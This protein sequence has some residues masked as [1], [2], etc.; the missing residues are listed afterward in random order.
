MY[1]SSSC[2]RTNSGICM[3]VFSYGMFLK[4]QCHEIFD[5]RFSTW[6]SFPKA[7]DY[8][9]RAVFNFFKNSRRY[10]QLRVTPVANGK[11]LQLEKAFLISF[12]HLW[13]SRVGIQIKFFL[14]VHFKLSAVW[15]YSHC[16]PPLSTTPSELV[17]KFAAG[18]V[19]ISG[20]P[21]LVIISA[22]FR[23]N[24]KWPLCYFQGLG[25]RWFMKKNLK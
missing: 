20:A 15:Y 23:K 6:I 1:F 19:D 17:A 10:L 18:V 21:W 13:E 14:P 9:I 25:G 7:P 4:G 12:G 24:S 22:N 3:Y 8:T 5:F 16:L 11:N 2:N